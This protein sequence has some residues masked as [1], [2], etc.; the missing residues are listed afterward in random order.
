MAIINGTPGI[1]MILGTSGDTLSVD[2]AGVLS[3]GDFLL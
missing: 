3:A 2:G 1:D